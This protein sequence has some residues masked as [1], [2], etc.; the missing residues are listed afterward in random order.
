MDWCKR[1][2]DPEYNT[3][4]W[5]DVKETRIQS[6]TIGVTSLDL[7]HFNPQENQWLKEYKFYQEHN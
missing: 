1:D 3:I 5:T 2:K 6:I 4:Q 7:S